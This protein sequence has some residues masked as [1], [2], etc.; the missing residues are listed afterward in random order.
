MAFDASELS[1]NSF[2]SDEDDTHTQLA[3]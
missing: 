3:K 2:L 1:R